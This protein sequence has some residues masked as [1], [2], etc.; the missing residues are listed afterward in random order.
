MQKSG[1][2]KC[3]LSPS[4]CPWWLPPTSRLWRRNCPGMGWRKS[5]HPSWC[6]THML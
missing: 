1:S 3:P 5:G 6:Q 2:C 4:G